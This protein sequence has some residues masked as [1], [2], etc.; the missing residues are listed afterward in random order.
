MTEQVVTPRVDRRRA[1]GGAAPDRRGGYAGFA[2]AHE[3]LDALSET[4]APT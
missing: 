2:A 1:A 4:V 3:A